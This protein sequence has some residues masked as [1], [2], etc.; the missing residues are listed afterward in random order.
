MSLSPL[1]RLVRALE[2]HASAIV[3][4]LREQLHIP[5]GATLHQAMTEVSGP[6]PCTLYPVPSIRP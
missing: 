3:A 1:R 2:L 5:P 6:V 4:A